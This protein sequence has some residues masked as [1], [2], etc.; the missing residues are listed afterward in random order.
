MEPQDSGPLGVR[1]PG[2]SDN[3]LAGSGVSGGAGM[4][5]RWFRRV[6][7]QYP[8]GVCVVTAAVDGTE[9]T[10]MVIGSFTSDRK[11]VV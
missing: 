9:L 2:T 3:F 5:P 8:T 10:G 4:D 6:L 1:K 11:S 7:G